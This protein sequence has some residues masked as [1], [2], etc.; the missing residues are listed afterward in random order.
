VSRWFV[1]AVGFVSGGC[2]FEWHFDNM[3]GD[4]QQSI[5][6]LVAYGIHSMEITTNKKLQKIVLGGGLAARE[7]DVSV[8]VGVLG[9]GVDKD[10]I[11]DSALKIRASLTSKQDG[12]LIFD[13]RCI[14]KGSFYIRGISPEKIEQ[15]IMVDC[16]SILFPFVRSA[17]ANIVRECGLPPLLLDDVD[18]EEMRI[19]NTDRKKRQ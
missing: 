16:A 7:M 6:K 3:D 2:S 9:S 13:M 17:I 14:Y 10:N 1:G 15:V 4:E 5:V 12:L 8:D 18:F 19:G 11:A